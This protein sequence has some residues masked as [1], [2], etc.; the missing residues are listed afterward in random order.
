MNKRMKIK[1]IKVGHIEDK[2]I[3]NFQTPFGQA[4]GTWIGKTPKVEKEYFVE[5]EIEEKIELG[6]NIEK[7]EKMRT[8]I[9]YENSV[10]KIYGKIEE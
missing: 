3:V 6:I 5:L 10:V 1:I 8:M 4:L 2:I 9:S 7:N